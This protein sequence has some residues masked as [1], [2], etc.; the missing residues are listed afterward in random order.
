MN[1][2]QV[3]LEDQIKMIM[4]EE[5]GA[6]AGDYLIKAYVAYGE[7]TVN[8]DSISIEQYSK[9]NPNNT[10]VIDLLF[11]RDKYKNCKSRTRVCDSF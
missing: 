8:K 10:I 1:I 2:I 5:M 3:L 4:N 9:E 6:L 7:S 11:N